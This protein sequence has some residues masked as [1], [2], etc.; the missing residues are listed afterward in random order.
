MILC[1]F[2]CKLNSL[3][4]VMWNFRKIFLRNPCMATRLLITAPPPLT[5]VKEICFVKQLF[6]PNDAP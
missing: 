6:F 4:D 1:K 2:K 5:I 3:L